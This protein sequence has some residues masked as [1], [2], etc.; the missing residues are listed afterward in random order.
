MNNFRDVGSA[1]EKL[2][3]VAVKGAEYDSRERHC[4]SPIQNVCKGLG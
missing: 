1:W 3:D 4:A 2:S